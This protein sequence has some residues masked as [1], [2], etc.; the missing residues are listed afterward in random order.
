[1]THIHAK[2][3]DRITEVGELPVEYR[4]EP[5]R[6]DDEIAQPEVAVHDHP[7]AGRWPVLVEPSERQ[8]ERRAHAVQLA[9]ALAVVRRADRGRTKP[10]TSSTRMALEPGDE[11]AALPR[12]PRAGVGEPLV[13]LDPSG[14][15]LAGHPRS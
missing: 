13:A 10:G 3:L 11:L 9:P 1:M 2:I 14:E 8:L 12:Q 7:S 15:R 6:V 5:V 4:G